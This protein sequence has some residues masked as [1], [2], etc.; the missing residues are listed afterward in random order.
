MIA[1]NFITR[2]FDNTTKQLD[3]ENSI[4]KFICEMEFESLTKTIEV[5]FVTFANDQKY[6][7]SGN[8]IVNLYLN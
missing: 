6:I 8:G 2:M 3:I 7:Y 1:G 5:Y 4:S